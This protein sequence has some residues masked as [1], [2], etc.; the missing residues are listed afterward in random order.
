MLL[1]RAQAPDADI[2]VWTA[3]AGDILIIHPKT[4]HASLPRTGNDGGRRLAFT[5]RW[6]GSD[7]VWEPTP[8]TT[9]SPFD[10]HPLMERG[11]PPPETLFPIVWRR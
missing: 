1:E 8:L 2:R 6:V 5:V 7:V 10:T 3:K 9:L 11:K 4:I